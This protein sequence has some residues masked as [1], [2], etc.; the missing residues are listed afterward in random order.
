MRSVFFAIA[1]IVL[2]FPL[3]AQ[4]NSS[5]V[6]PDDASSAELTDAIEFINLPTNEYNFTWRAGAISRFLRMH[7]KHMRE[8]LGRATLRNYVER[9]VVAL[10]L[11][12]SDTPEATELLK[13]QAEY[14]PLLSAAPPIGAG[15][16]LD[17][18]RPDVTHLENLYNGVEEANVLDIAWGMY[19]V[20]GD[21]EILGSFIR[22]AARRSAPTE[23]A[24]VY[25]CIPKKGRQPFPGGAEGLD[26]VAMAA[27][28]SV[29]SRAEQKAAFAAEVERVLLLQSPEV[30][31]GFR[32]PLPDF[33]QNKSRY[34]AE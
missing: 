2:A 8:L 32:E 34:S 10:A 22:C 6:R 26:I 24:Y 9:N 23:G 27:K 19:D 31:A 17:A 1:L 7:T 4:A 12:L 21:E 29:L 11:W 33:E 28:W 13:L 20:S 14:N 15:V 30:Q 18:P 5:E 25:W 3:Y 16:S